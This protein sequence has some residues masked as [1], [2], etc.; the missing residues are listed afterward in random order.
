METGVPA[1]SPTLQVG[2]EYEPRRAFGKT[3]PICHHGSHGDVTMAPLQFG[4]YAPQPH[5]SVGSRE[6]VRSIAG[7]LAPLPSHTVDPAFELGRSVLCA[8]DA[9]GFDIILFAERHLGADLEAW[10]TAS[11]LGAATRRIR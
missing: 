9:A 7:A 1:P 2:W 5:I 8:A 11:A 3:K 10:I 6:I 4:L